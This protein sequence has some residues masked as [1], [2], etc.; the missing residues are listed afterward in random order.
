MNLLR[1]GAAGAVGE[2]EKDVGLGEGA[3]EAAI[4]GVV[5]DG[6]ALAVVAG[7]DVQ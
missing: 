7:E 6:E 4:A 5:E 1:F 2:S 3:D